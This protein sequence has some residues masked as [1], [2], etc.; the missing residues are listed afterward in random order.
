M[1]PEP[2]WISERRR[3]RI[4][5]LGSPLG[6]HGDAYGLCIGPQRDTIS[7]ARS[8]AVSAADLIDCGG[9]SAVAHAFREM[10]RSTPSNPDEVA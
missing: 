6:F 5:A 8:D 9:V 2:T 7:E 4:A 3:S 10:Y 1:L